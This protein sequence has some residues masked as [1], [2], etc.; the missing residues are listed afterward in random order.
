MQNKRLF[1]FAAIFG[2]AFLAGSG[3][4][5]L[6]REFAHPDNPHL[7]PALTNPDVFINVPQL[8]ESDNAVVQLPM[9]VILLEFDDL[10][11][12]PAHTPAYFVDMMFGVNRANGRPSVA[13][14]YRESSN[15]RL[16]LVPA[17]AGDNHG[18]KD[19]IVGWVT[20]QSQPGG[21]FDYYNTHLEKKRAEG[22]IR[23]DPFFDFS[24]YDRNQDGVITSDELAII[25]VNANP[26]FGANTR[27]TDPGKVPVENGAYL[28]Y[29]AMTGVTEAVHVGAVAHEL[30][31][32][33]FGL[34]D[35]YEP[36]GSTRVADGYIHN[37]E[38][39]PPDPARY[40]LMGGNNPASFL[41][42]LD[43]WAKIHLGFVKPLVIT[44]DGRYTLFNIE[45]DRSFAVQT[46]QPE[47]VII[48]DPLR[49]EPYKEYFI[50]ENRNREIKNPNSNQMIMDRGLTVWLTDENAPNWPYGLN[51]RKTVRLIRRA[52]PWAGETESLWDGSESSY[53][54][55][56]HKSTPRNTNWT[57]GARSYI[58]ITDV[59]A[60][61]PA[62]SFNITMPPIFVAQAAAGFLELGTQENPF[63]TIQAAVEAVPEPPRT[64]RIAGGNYPEKLFITTPVTLKAWGSEHVFIGQ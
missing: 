10:A 5:Q 48:Y 21:S 57:D 61:G 43:P 53:Y 16:L 18:A 58:E 39:Y 13:E 63:K 19:G 51:L 36:S 4:A 12:L 47:A 1:F 9:L 44:H 28:V 31:H 40:S 20:A 24:L 45:T 26:A 25:V 8:F 7:D 54:D 33:V 56:T 27:K 49:S 6:W 37:N 62:I 60:A 29:Q 14:T 38:W 42:H 46:S 50:L 55:I 30:G 34:G 11:A 32:Q 23:A 2:L 35:L 3:Y 52:G 64:I 59:S 22:V 15:G 17:T 41:S